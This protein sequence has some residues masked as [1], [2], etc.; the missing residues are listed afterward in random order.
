VICPHAGGAKVL[1]TSTPT[2]ASLATA[3]LL[4]LES[5]NLVGTGC[6]EKC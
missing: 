5:S 2:H 1:K 3:A 4:I 6:L